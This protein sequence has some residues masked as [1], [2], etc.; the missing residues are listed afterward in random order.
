MSREVTLSRSIGTPGT[1]IVTIR[2]VLNAPIQLYYK[3]IHGTLDAA[4]RTLGVSIN[5]NVHDK[6]KDVVSKKAFAEFM[7]ERK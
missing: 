5:R 1:S 3:V 2:N 4:H 7:A 6:I